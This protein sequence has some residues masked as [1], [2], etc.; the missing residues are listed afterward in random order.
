MD[1]NCICSGVEQGV[2]CGLGTSWLFCS[3]QARKIGANPSANHVLFKLFNYMDLQGFL[4]FPVDRGSFEV[5]KIQLFLVREQ[6]LSCLAT[7]AL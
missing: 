4:M 3:L 1:A 6:D 7:A 5:I 2:K